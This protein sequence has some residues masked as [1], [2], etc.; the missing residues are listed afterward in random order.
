MIIL[1]S[2]GNAVLQPVEK[3]HISGGICFGRDDEQCRYTYME[4]GRTS[5]LHGRSNKSKTKM[6]C[7]K[8]VPALRFLLAIAVLN[9]PLHMMFLAKVWNWIDQV[10]ALWW[11]F[12]LALATF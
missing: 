7:R 8:L 1:R 9:L 12:P 10:Q 4:E 5:V 3:E 11:P 2:R 6:V